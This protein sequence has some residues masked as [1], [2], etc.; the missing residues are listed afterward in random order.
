M[1]DR[2]M[3][4][5]IDTDIGDDIDDA[6]ALAF[7]LNSPEVD[8][9]AVTTVFGAVDVRTRLA[10][11]LLA[12]WGRGDIPVGTGR[13]APLLGSAPEH[14]PNQAVVLDEGER[15]PGA[16]PLAA[17]ELIL[18]TAAEA[19]GQLTLLTI[20]AMTNAAVALLRDPSLA[21]RARLVVMGGHV[22]RQQA[23][24]NIRCDPEAARVC[25]ESGIPLTLVGLDVTMQ[26]RMR[27]E[28]VD[29]VAAR[30]TAAT[31]LLSRLIDAWAGT[32]DG[33]GKRT[34]ILH[35]PLAVAVAFRPELVTLERR[36]MAVETRGE[37]TRAFTVPVPG[38]ANAD[39]CVG[40]DAAGFVRL[41]QER[42][43]A[44]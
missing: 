38:E 9:R 7:A 16:S 22:G 14:M 33:Q 26:C 11:K 32:G 24:W 17:D 35:D 10:L 41:F 39:V 6:L 12:T 5:L 43:L 28:D 19:G 29:A 1:P 36:R 15:L 42:L 21:R 31:T 18:Q 20:G 4:I 25:L 8:L 23:E 27:R 34:P 13:A 30:G 3:P 44:R 37:F 40:V 2:P